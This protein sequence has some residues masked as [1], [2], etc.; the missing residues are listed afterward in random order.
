M[1]RLRILGWGGVSTP[2]QAR[3]E[4]QSLTAQRA[5]IETYCVRENGL[6]IDYLEVPGFSRDYIDFGEM[7]DDMSRAG[8][9]AP[10]QLEA[11]WRARD[12]DVFACYDAHRF[13]RTLP[14]ITY[15]GAR[16]VQTAGAKMFLTAKNM[17]IDAQNFNMLASLFGM[18]A[19]NEIQVLRDRYKFGMAGKADRGLFTTRV[20]YTH[21][22]RGEG[23]ERVAEVNESLR[24]FFDDFAELFLQ[25]TSYEE[26]GIHM[27]ARG[28][29]DPRTHTQITKSRAWDF[30]HSPAVWGH[31]APGFAGREGAW[32]YDPS[33]PVPEGI[34]IRRNII[35]A[36]WDETK[37]AAIIAELHRR[38]GLKG[39]ASAS[40]VYRYTSLI[41]CNKC[42][43]TMSNHERGYLY[44][45]AW[46]KLRKNRHKI[47]PNRTYAPVRVLDAQ[48]A[49]F[50]Q[51]WLDLIPDEQLAP[52]TLVG[53]ARPRD[54]AVQCDAIRREIA[55]LTRRI[56]QMILSQSTAPTNVTHIYA[57][58]IETAS[59]QLDTLR[60]ELVRVE[61]ETEPAS[62]EIARTLTLE[63]I[64]ATGIQRFMAMPALAFNQAM[65]RL[66]GKFKFFVQDGEIVDLRD[67]PPVYKPTKKRG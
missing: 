3:D 7:R 62:V 23:R 36:I 53:S 41:R 13:G 58:Q 43:Y 63:E 39:K 48:V 35:P 46:H 18:V 42:G 32:V 44:C 24:R 56:E 2:E 4:K 47:C 29:L 25:G 21:I 57:K 61:A 30:I 16:I 49:E 67:D 22:I 19:A 54:A 33:A 14:I 6:M 50:L 1:A 5:A 64:R 66:L 12:F 31:I 52:P 28:H 15:I 34:N 40:R 37:R 51:M 8:I 9:T 59:Q 17:Y 60:L 27:A 26:L 45:S 65:H 38:D 10:A 55:S 11:H 20:P